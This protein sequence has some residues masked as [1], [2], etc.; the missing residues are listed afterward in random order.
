MITC[1][2][3]IN[4]ASIS[5]LVLKHE[6]VVVFFLYFMPLKMVY[7]HFNFVIMLMVLNV[8]FSILFSL[9]LLRLT[10]RTTSTY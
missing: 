4:S 10:K 8:D 9:F 7:H 5:S 3:T 6:S 1:F 2:Y